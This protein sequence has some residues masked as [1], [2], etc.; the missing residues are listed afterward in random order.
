MLECFYCIYDRLYF[1]GV[2]FLMSGF[3]G[4]ICIY[5]LYITLV[6]T[7]LRGI[8]MTLRSK[9]I[10]HDFWPKPQLPENNPVG[11]LDEM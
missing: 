3:L 10:F 8:Q 1:S 5:T 6:H 4:L 11:I 7:N 9:P 2:F